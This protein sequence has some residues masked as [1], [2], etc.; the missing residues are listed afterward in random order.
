MQLKDKQG[1]TCDLCHTAYRED[2]E[3]ASFD[4]KKVT[5]FNNIRPSLDDM[6]D[7]KV[8][9]S[10]DICTECYDDLRLKIVDNYQKNL[11]NG[12][13]CEIS[14]EKIVG[15]CK[16]YYIIITEVEVN[17]S[18]QPY[19]CNKCGSKGFEKTKEC[20]CGCKE[21]R[22][23]AFVIAGKRDLEI[24]ISELVY[25]SWVAKRDSYVENSWTSKS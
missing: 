23:N 10:F 17:M 19:V 12:L 6:L 11:K 9:T 8:L 21:F 4:A 1:I 20:K 15:T 22:R 25:N 24:S 14:G 7:S 3:Y 16:F 5:M 18:R 2:F 13:C